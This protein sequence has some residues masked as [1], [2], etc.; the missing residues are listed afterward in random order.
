MFHGDLLETDCPYS[1][2]S[3]IVARDPSK[4]LSAPAGA[5]D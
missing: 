4:N 3:F 1:A 5:D 2:K